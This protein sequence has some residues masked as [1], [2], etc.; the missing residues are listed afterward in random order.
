MRWSPFHARSRK[1]AAVSVFS[2]FAGRWP[3]GKAGMGPFP[4]P[5]LAAQR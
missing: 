1:F 2:F 5:V 4:N 3:L